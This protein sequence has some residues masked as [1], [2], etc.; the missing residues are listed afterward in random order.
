MKP[1]P[2]LPADTA[3][4]EALLPVAISAGEA[5]LAVRRAGAHVEWKADSSPVTEADRAAEAV[6]AAAL[7]RIAPA[8]PVI[9]EEAAYEGRVPETGAEFFLV[10]PLDGTREF[11]RGGNDFTV[12]IG[13]IRDCSPVVGVIY[14]PETGKLFWGVVGAGAWRAL[15]VDGVV[16]ER[17]PI[18]VRA[19][20]DGGI[21]VVASRSHRSPE[22]DTY[23]RR[24]DV[25]K[26]VSAGS[27][28]KFCAVASGKADLYPRMGTTMQWDT[29]AG[30]AILRA[31]GGMVVT[32]D[33]EPL[34][35][36]PGEKP[37][38]E[39]Y[40]NPW[41]VAAGSITPLPEAG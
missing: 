10:D 7:A 25:E 17:Q 39:G 20:P 29:A 12:N 15:V 40:R 6:I 36:G 27:S 11:V 23:I 19:A 16:G 28:M 13:L 37:G 30:D 21:A 24:Y 26:L 22:T 5:I 1:R 14:L 32:L 9:A 31:A 35:Y 18:R 41:F 2:D 3:L 38:C 33:G 34:T 4:A 8:V